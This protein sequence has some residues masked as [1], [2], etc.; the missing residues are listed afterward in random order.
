MKKVMLLLALPTMLIGV[1]FHPLSPEAAANFSVTTVI[2]DNQIDK[3]KTYF[4]LRMKPGQKQDLEVVLKND[5]DKEI[6]VETNANTAVTNDNG[7]V[8]Y[9]QT[10]PK[11]DKSL[12][13]PFSSIATMEDE[14]VLPANSSKTIKVAVTMPDT[15]FDGIILG[16]LQFIEK[17]DPDAKKEDDQG[18]QIKNRY[19]Y[20]VGVQLS[21]NDTVVEPDMKLQEIKPQQINYRNVVTVNLQNP[22][23]TII[24]PL[25]IDAKIYKSGDNQ[26]LHQAKRDNLRMAPN[27][28]F[29][30]AI[31]WE[32]Q[33]LK[34][35]KY[36]LKMVAT[37]GDNTWKWDEE[38]TIKG[39]D[40]KKLND[41]AIDLE[42]D[43][44]W[45]YI[46]GGA[47][48]LILLVLLAFWL[49]KRSKKDKDEDKKE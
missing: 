39:D 41:K 26:V 6:T 1:L 19:A 12:K 24:K 5:T 25:M 2:P 17:E 4:D 29:N 47:L 33:P 9:S 36:R 35:G 21:E 13:I 3:S 8:D 37:S 23:A 40:A 7:I 16:G 43:Y 30:Y 28:N 44:T 27:S 42:K 48:A 15:A 18:V 34:A 11:L 22:E 45:W 31:D 46:A 10:N 38:F 14:V 20:V 49:G 32:N